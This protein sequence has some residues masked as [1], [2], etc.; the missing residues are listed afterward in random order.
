MS[1]ATEAAYEARCLKAEQAVAILRDA[2]QFYANHNHWMGLTESS[3]TETVL[4]AHG[5]TDS[6]DASKDGWSM[7][8]WA[9]RQTAKI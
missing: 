3:E 1:D 8:E 9:L 5:N 2:V 6:F 4:I 7:A